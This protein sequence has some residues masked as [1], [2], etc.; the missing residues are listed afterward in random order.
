MRGLRTMLFVCL[1]AV[2]AWGQEEAPGVFTG[3]FLS[4]FRFVS[5]DGVQ[6][7]FDQHLHLRRGPRLWNLEVA[8][9]P[10]GNLRRFLDRMSF[11][12]ARFGGDPYE[13]LRVAWAKFGAYRLSYERRKSTYFYQDILLPRELANFL[14]SNAGDLHLAD[15]ERVQDTATLNIWMSSAVR[16]NLQFDRFILQGG[17]STTM[18]VGRDEFEFERVQHQTKNEYLLSLDIDLKKVTITIEERVHDYDND[19]RFFLPG[20][21]TGEDAQNIRYPTQLDFYFLDMPYSFKSYTH[22]ARAVFRPTDRWTLGAAASWTD[23]T[24]ELDY[25]ETGQGINFDRSLLRVDFSGK[26]SVDRTLQNYEIDASYQMTSRLEW[27]GTLRHVVFDQ[28][29]VMNVVGAAPTGGEW[30][31]RITGLEGGLRMEPS[32]RVS[33]TVGVRRESREVTE[34][35]RRPAGV[36]HEYP[37]TRRT[38]LVGTLGF[39]PSQNIQM[40]VDYQFGTFANPFVR[41]A[42]TDFHRLR[43][44][45]RYRPQGRFSLTGTYQFQQVRNTDSDWAARI[46]RAQLEGTY[47]VRSVN[48]RLSYGLQTVRQDVTTSIRSTAPGNPVL[49]EWPI[50]YEGLSHLVT[51]DLRWAL[52]SSLILGGAFQMQENRKTWPISWMQALGYAEWNLRDGYVL[53]AD[54]RYVRYREKIERPIPTV[55]VSPEVLKYNDYTAHIVEVGVGYR[56]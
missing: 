15:Y 8:L 11:E 13:T 39:R 23:L 19:F 52:G 41:T 42:P 14:V 10:T 44:L 20:F 56:W 48:L 12:I 50:L 43:I 9:E 37:T 21:S 18:D 17:G 27:F 30:Q 32:E 7:K 1:V 40:T 47:K 24:M 22:G 25:T 55:P 4:G 45:G 53:R 35:R 6:T 3:G 5:V 38:G 33:L 54:Y 46:H 34:K 31:F 26:G 29:G 51:A 16:L 49:M 28:D 36:T 2:P